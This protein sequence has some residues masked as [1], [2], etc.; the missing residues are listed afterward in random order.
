MDGR[1]ERGARTGRRGVT[2]AEG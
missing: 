2:F 1:A